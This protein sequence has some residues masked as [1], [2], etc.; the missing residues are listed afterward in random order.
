MKRIAVTSVAI[1]LASLVF[2]GSGSAQDNFHF[3]TFT[4]PGAV[5]LGVEQTNIAG[6]IVGYK[7]ISEGAGQ[8]FE[9][10]ANGTITTLVDPN[11]EG[12]LTA[13]ATFAEGLNDEG[14]V[15]GYYYNTAAGNYQGFFYYGGIYVNY[16]LP[17]YLEAPNTF[18]VGI[19]DLGD[20]T[21]FYYNGSAT[22]GFLNQEGET[23]SFSQSGAIFTGG[24]ALNNFDDV[25]GFYQLSSTGPY[26]GY[27]RSPNGEIKTVD[28]PGASTAE[29]LGTVV[30]GINDNGWISGHFWDSEGN[31]HGFLGISE[32]GFYRLIQIDVPGATATSGGGLNQ[33]GQVVGHWV[34]SSG[35]ELGYIAT[36]TGNP[37]E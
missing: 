34:N 8:G 18:L 16:E 11:D 4:V 15:S 5:T 3:A 6:T 22:V 37:S 1:A 23:Q 25:A 20:F 14:I 31:E 27:V 13:G 21:G 35:E 26:H 36:F 28:F 30:L 33:F 19:N 32:R 2:P 10:F 29:N 7:I 12:G 24:Y 9:R 17:S